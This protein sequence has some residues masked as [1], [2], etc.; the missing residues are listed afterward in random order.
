MLFNSNI[1]HVIVY[2]SVSIN[3][4]EIPIKTIKES[5]SPPIVTEN[6]MENKKVPLV[7]AHRGASGMY[8]EHTKL[9]YRYIEVFYANICK[10]MHSKLHFI[11]IYIYILHRIDWVQFFFSGKL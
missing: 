7:I 5:L 3:A 9:A 4:S 1:L 6:T 10:I 2:G 11:Y 8:P